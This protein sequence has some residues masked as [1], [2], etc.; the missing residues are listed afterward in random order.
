MH[1]THRMI[2]WAALLAG[3]AFLGLPVVVSALV[4]A[5]FGTGDLV[6]GSPSTDPAVVQGAR[7][8]GAIESGIFAIIAVGMGLLVI[9]INE[10]DDDA[11]SAGGRA[12][13]LVGQ[14]AAFGWLL[15]AAA[16]AATYSSVVD[17]A[18][19]FGGEGRAVFFLAHAMDITSAVFVASI[20]SGTY[21]LAGAVR[22]PV[23]R[24]L[25]RPLTVL[26]GIGGALI[27]VP[28]LFGFPWGAMLLIPLF[29]AVGVVF[30]RRAT[31]HP[32]AIPA[33]ELSR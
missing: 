22:R 25:G 11:H 1:N 17:T 7:W 12:H 9:G 14:A 21:W 10:L 3:L 4:P 5:V 15:V 26:A 29:V 19:P 13:L 32:L 23:A 8:L 28:N 18:S 27:L 24:V 2:G 33:P 20:A 16:S 31:R 30:L 6:I